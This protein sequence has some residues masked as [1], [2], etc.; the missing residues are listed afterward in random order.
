MWTLFL[1]V[2]HGGL[3]LHPTSRT[4]MFRAIFT[5]IWHTFWQQI[6]KETLGLY[7]HTER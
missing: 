5:S 7:Q 2:S 4:L 6:S 3:K 1:A